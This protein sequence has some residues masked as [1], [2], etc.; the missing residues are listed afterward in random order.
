[1]YG[2][3]DSIRCR[4]EVLKFMDRASACAL[5]LYHASFFHLLLA[6]SACLRSRNFKLCVQ[7]YGRALRNFIM[8]A[9]RSRDKYRE[10]G[11]VLGI[12]CNKGLI[13]SNG[14]GLLYFYLPWKVVNVAGEI[15]VNEFFRS[16]SVIISER[17]NQK[18]INTIMINEYRAKDLI[19]VPATR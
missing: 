18:Y 3:T 19:Q 7:I 14:L 8:A 16:I 13:S 15:V 1:M 6:F 9:A 5:C 12:H 10:K 4:F 2:S 11:G 17:Y